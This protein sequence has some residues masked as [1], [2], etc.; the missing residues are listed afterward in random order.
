MEWVL[1]WQITLLMGW[2][3]FCVAFVKSIDH[4]KRP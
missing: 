1:F 2:A 3:A 4:G